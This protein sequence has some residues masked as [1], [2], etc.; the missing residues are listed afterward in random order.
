MF[1]YF[2]MREVEYVVLEVGMGGEDLM[3]L[4]L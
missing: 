3:L 2:S 4:T 1:L